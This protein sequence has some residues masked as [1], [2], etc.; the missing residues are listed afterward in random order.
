MYK[1]HFKKKQQHINAL[2]KFAFYYF[3]WIPNNQ[4]VWE[5]FKATS[6]FVLLLDRKLCVAA[7]WFWTFEVV[8]C[9]FFGWSIVCAYYGNHDAFRLHK[10]E[11]EGTK[12][13]PAVSITLIRVNTDLLL[14]KK[15]RQLVCLCVVFNVYLLL[16]SYSL[17]SSVCN[18]EHL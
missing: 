5:R 17:Y 12:S 3:K 10:I 14:W 13:T 2:L 8:K 16:C 9:S 15:K 1:C 6:F 7:G 11:R 18:D 4:I